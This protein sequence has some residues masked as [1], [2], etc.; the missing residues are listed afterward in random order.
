MS[1]VQPGQREIAP[2]VEALLATFHED[3]W[4]KL[5]LAPV[6]S[7]PLYQGVDGLLCEVDEYGFL[8]EYGCKDAD[9]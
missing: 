3:T 7:S 5:E 6:H 9:H 2:S 8:A 1:E 4:L